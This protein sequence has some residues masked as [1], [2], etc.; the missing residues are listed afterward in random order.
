MNE[1]KKIAVFGISHKIYKTKRIFEAAAKNNIELD[2][3][4]F[5]EL[6]FDNGE[7]KINGG[8]KIDFEKYST[9]I[10]ISAPCY[11]ITIG[12]KKILFRLNKEFKV[13]LDYLRKNN[14]KVFNQDIMFDFPYYDKFFQQH[15]F[16]EKNIKSIE[17][18]HIVDNKYEKVESIMKAKKINYPIV[19]KE[20]LGGMGNGVFRADNERELRII[21]ESKRNGNLVFQPFIK[22]EGDFRV[23][24]C[25]G[26]SLGIMKRVAKEGDWLNNFSQGGSVQVYNDKDMEKFAESVAQKMKL[27][28]T[29]I[30]ILKTEDGYVIIEVNI[31]PNFEGFEKVF[32]GLDIADKILKKLQKAI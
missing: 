16:F 23:L 24:V 18:F 30:D 19:I 25:D 22:N 4:K 14:I 9:A 10:F 13:L 3:F 26:K 32:P 12:G 27:D 1:F 29:G 21:L 20:S 15:I 6:F 7:I 2:F 8:N 5:S 11:A 17:T 28:F 31:F